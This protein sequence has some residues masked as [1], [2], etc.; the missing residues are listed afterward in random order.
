MLNN[1]DI[2]TL[3]FFPSFVNPFVPN[4]PLTFHIS[5]ENRK[6]YG[7]LVISGDRGRVHWEQMG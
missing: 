1:I 4:A 3:A 7:F 2:L 5:P 6:P